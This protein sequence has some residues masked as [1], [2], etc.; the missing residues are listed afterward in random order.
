MDVLGTPISS[1]GHLFG[2]G[3]EEQFLSEVGTVRDHV[4]LVCS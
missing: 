1:N 2:T 4:H 3:G